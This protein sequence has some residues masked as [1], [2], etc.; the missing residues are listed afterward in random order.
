MKKCLLAILL[1]CSFLSAHCD[2]IFFPRQYTLISY[3]IEGIYSCEK[4]RNTKSTNMFWAGGGIVGSFFYLDEP[5]FGIETA[6]ERRRYFK[7][8]S[9][10]GFCFS[11]YLGVA[12]MTNFRNLCQNRLVYSKI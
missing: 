6:V 11:G 2:V 5:T 4:I 8:D 7:P 3:S 12:A 9:Y 10:K 1:A